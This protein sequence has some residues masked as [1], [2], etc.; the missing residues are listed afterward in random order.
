MRTASERSWGSESVRLLSNKKLVIAFAI[1]FAMLLWGRCLVYWDYPYSGR[2]I[3]KE[4]GKP[5]A[6][7]AV[8]AEYVATV[9]SPAGPGTNDI[10]LKEA[11]TD[12]EGEFHI[13]F[14]MTLN[15]DIAWLSRHPNIYVQGPGFE[16]I[17]AYE[18]DRVERG[19]GGE[20]VFRLQRLR[21]KEELRDNVSKG[22]PWRCSPQT[23]S[24]L[25][26]LADEDAVAVGLEPLYPKKSGNP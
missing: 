3:D 22:L 7:A 21:S 14:M 16:R 19:P 15:L 4:T 24:K 18:D 26:E 12:G 10:T 8:V 5:I 2:V 20:L 6:G 13:P 17:C 23:C 1:I 11:V 9:P 25:L